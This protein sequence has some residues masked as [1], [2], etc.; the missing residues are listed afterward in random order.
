MGVCS[1]PFDAVSFAAGKKA[2]GSS[3][4]GVDG[5]PNWVETIEGTLTNPWG[6]YEWE[7][8]KTL[9]NSGNATIKLTIPSQSTKPLGMTGEYRNSGMLGNTIVFSSLT[10]RTYYDEDEED[11]L[12]VPTGLLVRYSR[13]TIDPVNTCV[14]DD[15]YVTYLP[16]STATTLTIIHH[17][18]PDT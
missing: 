18:L 17:P 7:G 13:G 5:N 6:E 4:G 3:G 11:T 8:I 1:M 15:G 16:A 14:M 2:A 10:V 12:A 9:V